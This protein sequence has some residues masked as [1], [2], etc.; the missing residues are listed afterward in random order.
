ML[1]RFCST[2]LDTITILLCVRISN[3]LRLVR[4]KINLGS[5]GLT[6]DVENEA[7][8]YTV[9]K[10]QLLFVLCIIY[11][12]IVYYFILYLILYIMYYKN[13]YY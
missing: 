3:N 2:K 6:Q 1:G 5:S 13:Y 12:I 7:G 11:H 10:L 9:R 8:S 4:S